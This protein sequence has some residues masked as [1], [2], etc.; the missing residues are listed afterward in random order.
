MNFI[1][2][3]LRLTYFTNSIFRFNILYRPLSMAR[4]CAL[5]RNRVKLFR[6]S[7]LFTTSIYCSHLK[8]CLNILYV[9]NFPSLITAFSCNC[10]PHNSIDL[11]INLDF[12]SCKLMFALILNCCIIN[13]TLEYQLSLPLV[14]ISLL[15]LKA[16]PRR[17]S[18]LIS[19]SLL[20]YLI[21]EHTI[22][23]NN[24]VLPRLP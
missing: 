11:F 18:L 13:K 19:S 12:I 10:F 9:R 23:I 7:L 24:G 8:N 14:W 15:L 6:T 4:S 5:T 20:K 17:S 16:C 21:T 3:F 1:F 2:N 22:S